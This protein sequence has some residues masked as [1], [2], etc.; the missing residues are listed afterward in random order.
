MGSRGSMVARLKLKEIDGRAPPG[1]NR[2]SV[3]AVA[4]LPKAARKG[5][6][7]FLPALRRGEPSASLLA[8]ATPSNCG[9][10]LKP[11][12]PSRRRKGVGGRGNDLGYGKSTPG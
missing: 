10:L 8:E 4:L 11:A 12:S 2:F 1:V 9:K 3:A 6:C 5:Q 7:V